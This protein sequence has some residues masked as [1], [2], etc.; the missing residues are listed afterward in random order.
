V[1]ASRVDPRDAAHHIAS[2]NW[3]VY[4]YERSAPGLAM[5]VDE[6]RIEDE[7]DVLAVAAWAEH[8]ARGRRVVLYVEIGTP[9]APTLVRLR[10]SEP[11]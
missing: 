10:G 2:T 7:P 5:S 11:D 4:F 9:G 8:E 1:K 6:Y 3:R